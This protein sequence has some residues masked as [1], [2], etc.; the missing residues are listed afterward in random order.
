VIPT[1]SFRVGTIL[2]SA[3][4][5]VDVGCTSYAAPAYVEGPA[6]VAGP[7]EYDA[8]LVYTQDLPVVDIESYPSASYGGVDVY[9][10]S[11]RWYRRG[12]RG[13]AYYRQEPNELG[14]QR[15]EHW[16]HDHDQRWAQPQAEHRGRE[17]HGVQRPGVTEAQPAY[18]RA[19]PSQ[20]HR[21]GARPAQPHGEDA[22]P[23]QTHRDSPAPPPS[24]AQPH[25]DAP[26]PRAQPHRP[27]MPAPPAHTAPPHPKEAPPQPAPRPPARGAA[28]PAP[29][30]HR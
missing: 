17:E 18:P 10:V 11:G 8:D 25:R 7:A 23:A 3:L 6:V 2:A 12:P 15:E 13:W 29:E 21:A 27:E 5:V 19:E 26:P 22:R 1:T 28:E 30:Q 4:L 20:P 9:Y 14:R 24:Q 16:Q